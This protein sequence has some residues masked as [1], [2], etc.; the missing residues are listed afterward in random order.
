MS[1][2]PVRQSLTETYPTTPSDLAAFNK[3][4][5]AV[6]VRLLRQRWNGFAE[7]TGI[8]NGLSSIIGAGIP[9]NVATIADLR[10]L[11]GEPFVT[12]I[13]Q[14]YAT[15]GDGGGGPFSWDDT[16][17]NTTS[18]DNGGTI[19]VPTAL[20]GGTGAWIRQYSGQE[21]NMA[22]FGVVSDYSQTTKTGTDNGAKI[23]AAFDF[24]K[25]TGG[26]IVWPIGNYAVA[27]RVFVSAVHG[28][29]P[30]T[31]NVSMKG[32]SATGSALWWTGAGGANITTGTASATTTT[33]ITDTTKNFNTLGVTY[34]TQ[35]TPTSGAAAGQ[36]LHVTAVS[37]NG[38]TLTFQPVTA[39]DPT[40]TY[41]VDTEAGMFWFDTCSDFFIENLSFNT[42][43]NNNRATYVWCTDTFNFTCDRLR[44]TTNCKDNRITG[45]KVENITS[46]LT[47]PRGQCHFTNHVHTNAVGTPGYNTLNNPSIWLFGGAGAGP[48]YNAT[49]AGSG[50]IEESFDGVRLENTFMACLCGSWLLS[51]TGATG[52]GVHLIGAV[53]TTVIGFVQ[54]GDTNKHIIVDSTSRDNIFINCLNANPADWFNY[55]TDAG[56]HT[57]WFTSGNR[58]WPLRIPDVTDFFASSYGATNDSGDDDLAAL[59]RVIAVVQAAGLGGG[60][61]WLGHGLGYALSDSI[62]V[63]SNIFF[64]GMPG[65]AFVYAPAGKPAFIFDS[66]NECGLEN[67]TV[68][69]SKSAGVR[70][71]CTTLDCTR[72]QL[73]RCRFAHVN[74]NGTGS[75]NAALLIDSAG[76][77]N[78]VSEWSVEDCWFFGNNS[79]D[80]QTF[81]VN[82]GADTFTVATAMSTGT[83]V[84]V[85]N[86]GGGLPAPLAINT[87]YYVVN[88]NQLALTKG[89]AA[90]DITTAGTGTQTIHAEAAAI[91]ITG[92][93]TGYSVG[94]VSGGTW[95]AYRYG[96]DV[97]KSHSLIVDGVVIDS[98]TSD[99]GSMGRGVL[100]RGSAFRSDIRVNLRLDTTID[101]GL[102]ILNGASWNRFAANM[103]N[104]AATMILDNSGN[105]TNAWGGFDTSGAAYDHYPAT[106]QLA[107]GMG[108]F[109]HAPVTSQPSDLGLITDTT[110]GAANLTM[111]DVT[112]LG[113]SD[114]AKVN[115][116]FADTAAALNRIRTWIRNFGG[117][118]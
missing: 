31:A 21:I 14:S 22:W 58:T 109:S 114:P 36:I 87:Y 106:L 50:D 35:F 78:A 1:Q 61:I 46:S 57:V 103:G 83:E 48:I 105:G 89:G 80:S 98:I 91:K 92:T 60:E 115:D 100:L 64:K 86:S 111:V 56:T 107:G 74:F 62:T 67:I 117:T 66:V 27:T 95:H 19:I 94:R 43:Q 55:V 18:P 54:F 70:L 104:A 85:T 108:W 72:V 96:I 88:G 9:V 45:V 116:N 30:I 49:F 12:A 71:N 23:Q 16:H 51:S 3:D 37:A 79:D 26:V 112:T 84:T 32:M 69:C 63:P 110:G 73:R 97:D 29:D 39:L 90:I 11:E 44:C 5:I 38:Q 102:E 93:S 20:I 101:C 75:S 65:G 17:D 41:S 53:Q 113:V 34:G 40:P 99:T 118:A 33:T 25:H 28:A 13:V 68:Y 24:L 7:A 2:E 42:Q 8:N 81:T 6:L 82:T 4:Q 10:L 77:A 15:V 59:N 52:A 47:P 76:T